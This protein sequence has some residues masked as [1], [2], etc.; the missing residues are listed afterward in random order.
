M[1]EI[2][3]E[4]QEQIALFQWAN[5]AVGTMPDLCMLYHIPNGGLRTKATA[6]RLKKEGVKAGYPDIGLDV[7]WRGTGYT[8]CASN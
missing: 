1:K 8:G 4:S 6:A 3:S 5:L 2:A 7:A